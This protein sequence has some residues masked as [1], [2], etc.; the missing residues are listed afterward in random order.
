M[1][2]I[3]VSVLVFLPVLALAACSP[4]DQCQTSETRC[5]ADLLEVCGVDHTWYLEEN[6]YTH[7]GPN[8]GD[9]TCQA[10]AH[11]AGDTGHACLPA[12]LDG[13]SR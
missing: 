11:D 5:N 1:R 10:Y 9:F 3:F 7:S 13:A 4:T 2:A 12:P 6:C 8:G